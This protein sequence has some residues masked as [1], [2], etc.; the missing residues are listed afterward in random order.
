MLIENKSSIFPPHQMIDDVSGFLK[1]S[2]NKAR[3]PLGLGTRGR[4]AV[5]CC[6]SRMNHHVCGRERWKQFLV[7]SWMRRWCLDVAASFKEIL[8]ADK[9]LKSG[10]ST[11]ISIV[12]CISNVSW[13]TNRRSRSLLFKF[14]LIFTFRQ[15]IAPSRVPSHDT[16]STT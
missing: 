10:R 2:V 12:K 8:L 3:S 6:E 13:R 14:N 9:L 16:I 1:I 11:A 5:S 7:I 4:L 15:K